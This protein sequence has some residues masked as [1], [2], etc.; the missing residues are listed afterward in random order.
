[1]AASGA[2]GHFQGAF[3]QGGA[4]GPEGVRGHVVPFAGVGQSDQAAQSPAGRMKEGNP[5]AL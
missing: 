5:Q 2:E 3:V 4:G 1:M